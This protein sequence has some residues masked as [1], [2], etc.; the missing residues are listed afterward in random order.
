MLYIFK[1]SFTIV[2]FSSLPECYHGIHHSR[3]NNIVG[4]LKNNLKWREPIGFIFLNEI[5]VSAC[6][7]FFSDYSWRRKILIPV[8]CENS[9]AE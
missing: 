4:V 6:S 7:T 1:A 2:L 5:T 9:P 3:E 8:Q